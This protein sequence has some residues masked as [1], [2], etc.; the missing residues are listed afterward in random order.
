M[1]PPI[2]VDSSWYIREARSGRDPLVQL[3]LLAE[4]RDLA[5][6]GL[7]IVEVGRGL[8]EKRFLYRY[9]RAWKQM[10]YVPSDPGRWRET[11]GVAWQL[12]RVGRVLPLQDIHIAVC[13][14]HI[15]A[16]V[17]T[18]DAQFHEI[19]GIVATDRVV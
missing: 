5:V 12:D 8:R 15:G 16:V 17:L 2:L 18:V 3:S 7:V 6:C 9:E 19:P 14:A 11:L 4:V 10:R 13:A 1:S